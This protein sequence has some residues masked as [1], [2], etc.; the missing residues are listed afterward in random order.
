MVQMIQSTFS[1]E[2]YCF[3]YNSQNQREL[4][5][6]HYDVNRERDFYFGAT[7]LEQDNNE[8]E[9]EEQELDLQDIPVDPETEMSSDEEDELFDEINDIAQ[10]ETETDESD[11]DTDEEYL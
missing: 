3:Y 1:K 9:E 4:F 8:E 2:K 7:D 10:N 5:S 6:D 11:I